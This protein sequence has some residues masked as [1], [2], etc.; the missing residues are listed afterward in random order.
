M[1]GNSSSDATREPVDEK[2]PDG[3]ITK[4]QLAY[5]LMAFM[6]ALAV[7]AFGF[8]FTYQSIADNGSSHVHAAEDGA[9]E[10]TSP[11]EMQMEPLVYDDAGHAPHEEAF[12][13][14]GY[15]GRL[16]VHHHS[17]A[18]DDAFVRLCPGLCR[19]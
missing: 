4:R 17:Q 1:T 3:R 6:A 7:A 15:S 12:E 8:A 14:H 18:A 5:S 16:P 2:A 9:M 10:M 13:D 11:D 19:W